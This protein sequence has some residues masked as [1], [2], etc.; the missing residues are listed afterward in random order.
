MPHE[1][2]TY[3]QKKKDETNIIILN[4]SKKVNVREKN[5]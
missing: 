5:I 4:I 3:D 1:E 2:S